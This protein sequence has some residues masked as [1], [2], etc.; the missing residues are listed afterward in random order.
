MSKLINYQ[1]VSG[2]TDL[3]KN[4]PYKVKGNSTLAN[5]QILSIIGKGLL[6]KAV[7]YTESANVDIKVTIDGEIKL[8]LSNKNGA[9]G[10]YSATGFLKEESIRYAG[11]HYYT[12]ISNYVRYVTMEGICDYPVSSVPSN[13]VYS[14]TVIMS[15]DIPFNTSL[16]VEFLNSTSSTT[17]EYCVEYSLIQEV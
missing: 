1:P 14:Q 12:A 15:Q 13:P 9:G 5:G 10:E 16:L 3:L 7:V 8:Y 17:K 4:A 2:G 11:S 6:S